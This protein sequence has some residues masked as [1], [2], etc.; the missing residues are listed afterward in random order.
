MAYGGSEYDNHDQVPMLIDESEDESKQW[1]ARHVSFYDS[2]NAT[3]GYHQPS[4]SETLFI[5][6]EI[7]KKIASR[8]YSRRKFLQQEDDN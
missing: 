6:Y 8:R 5:K 4:K 3:L 2:G 1:E 7:H